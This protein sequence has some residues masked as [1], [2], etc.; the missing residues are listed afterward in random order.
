MAHI[1]VSYHYTTLPLALAIEEQIEAVGLAAWANP[2]PEPGQIWYAW[3]GEA[4][5]DAF[6]TISL[7]SQ[8]ARTSEHLAYEWA[9]AC[10]QGQPVIPVLAEP[11]DLHP[12]LAALEPLDFH[13]E[14]AR[15][16]DKLLARVQAA[17]QQAGTAAIAYE[18]TSGAVADLVATLNGPDAAGRAMALEQLAALEN[19]ALL[20][21]AA[22]HSV[23]QDMR[24][25]AVG[26]LSAR[27]VPDGVPGLIGMLSDENDSIRL[28]AI[29]ALTRFGPAVVPALSMALQGDHR[30]ARRGAITAL[31]Q[32]GTEDVIPSLCAVLTAQDWYLTRTAAVALGRLGDERGVPGLIVA[33]DTD[34]P[35]LRPLVVRAL[36]QIGTPAA[37]AALTSAHVVE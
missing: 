37:L 6:V 30:L 33:L 11:V 36:E 14:T 27:G 5:R 25:Q 34:D 24:R 18:G 23:Y 16:W 3:I 15:P 19:P 13:D 35:H 22:L 1:F 7:M 28:D 26:F 17:A 2:L 32:I 8:A 20:S 4:I 9:F 31:A 29:Q 21:T 10:G 12:A